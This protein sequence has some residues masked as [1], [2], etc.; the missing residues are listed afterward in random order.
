LT[1]WIPPLSD[2]TVYYWRIVAKDDNGT[3]SSEERSFQTPCTASPS[4]PSGASPANE[5]TNVGI[6]DDISWSGGNSACAGLT[7]E[8]DVYFGTTSSPPL[9]E[10]NV[11]VKTWDPGTLTKGV[12]YYWKIV[13][14]DDNGQTTS[15]VWRFQTELP[16]CLDPPL[17]ACEPNPQNNKT[18]VNR[19]A[20]LAWGCGTSQCGKAVTYDVYF[21]TSADLGDEQ[22][23]GSSQS[24]SFQLPRLNAGTKYYWKIITKDANGATSSPVWSF[25]TKS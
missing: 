15:P 9:A 5:A 6:D 16:P 24:T 11:A 1:T 12:T 18:N 19:D 22:K 4:A 13:A 3:S 20:N 21:G 25:T 14:K 10:S 7:A 8:Y 2:D 17:A 23:V